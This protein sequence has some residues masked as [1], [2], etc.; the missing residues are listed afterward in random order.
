[1]NNS[2]PG[3]TLVGAIIAFAILA[4][5]ALSLTALFVFQRKHEISLDRKVAAQQVV[6]NTAASLAAMSF[7]ALVAEC[8]KRNALYGPAVTP[9]PVPGKCVVGGAL[10][11]D[12]AVATTTPGVLEV[13]RN[14]S[15]DQTPSGEICVE[16]PMCQLLAGGLGINV[17]VR[18]YWKPAANAVQLSSS[19]NFDFR[20]S[21]W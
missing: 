6:F 14:F 4:I 19:K 7:D 15:G 18:G 12:P 1:M 11:T 8:T 21:R 5:V 13:R 3:F 2:Q 20:R 17:T 16:L 10:S 9:V